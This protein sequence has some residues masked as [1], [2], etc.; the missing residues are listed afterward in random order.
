MI[1]NIPRCLGDLDSQSHEDRETE[2]FIPSS[3]E[4][5]AATEVLLEDQKSLA[6]IIAERFT[7][8][9]ELETVPPSL[10]LLVL[11]ATLVASAL[12]IEYEIEQARIVPATRDDKGPVSWEVRGTA[13][14]TAT[15]RSSPGFTHSERFDRAD[16]VSRESQSLVAACRRMSQA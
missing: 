10:G 7:S 11:K 1:D 13:R 8:C 9:P 3:P 6:A 12:S 16:K 15:N 14:E 2:L 5:S 4:W